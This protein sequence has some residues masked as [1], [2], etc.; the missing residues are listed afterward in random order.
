MMVEDIYF[1]YDSLR[2]KTEWEIN[3][4]KIKNKK[5]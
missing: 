5:A 2:V 3:Y 1:R 4:G